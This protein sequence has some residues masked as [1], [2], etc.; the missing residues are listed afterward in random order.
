MLPVSEMLKLDPQDNDLQ[1]SLAAL[2]LLKMEAYT[3][4]SLEL[5]KNT[6]MCHFNKRLK[7]HSH[8]CYILYYSYNVIFK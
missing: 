8:D 5:T 6:G 1:V 7:K 2:D 3:E 4:T